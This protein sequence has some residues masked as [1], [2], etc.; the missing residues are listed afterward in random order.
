ML[1]PLL[2]RSFFFFLFLLF[3]CY[4]SGMGNYTPD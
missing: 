4:I 3:S 1:L 2:R